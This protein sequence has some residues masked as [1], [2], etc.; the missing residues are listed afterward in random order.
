MPSPH[1]VSLTRVAL[2][3]CVIFA[4]AALRVW[5]SGRME[6]AFRIDEVHKISETY[7]LRLAE[8][9]DFANRDWFMDPVE[10]SNP[11][12]GK[13]LFGAAV[14]AAGLPLPEDLTVAALTAGGRRIPPPERVMM[15]RRWL[16]PARL[17]SLFATAAT[18][19]LVFMI[20]TRVA[21]VWAALLAVILQME[22]FLTQAFSATAVFDPLLTLAIVAAA[23]PAMVPI[24]GRPAW[25]WRLLLSGAMAGLA[26]EIRASGLVAALA[27]GVVIIGGMASRSRDLRSSIGGA[28]AAAAACVSIATSVNP[29]YWSLPTDPRVPGV[30]RSPQWLPGRIVSRYALQ[31]GDLQTILAGQPRFSGAVAKARFAFEYLF[32]DW[33]GIALLLGLVL[34]VLTLWRSDFRGWRLLF[35]WAAIVATVLVAWLP[36]AYPRYLLAAVPPLA[37]LSSLGWTAAISLAVRGVRR[38]NRSTIPVNGHES[39][40]ARTDESSEPRAHV[41][42]G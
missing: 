2:L 35:G 36:V 19:A 9:G 16:R 15:Y 28:L 18:A 4:A 24:A 31:M 23:A 21:G 20:V 17:V 26:F 25:M 30:F 27:A 8:R 32:G 3:A 1:S 12:V 11:P 34:A 41:G 5:I 38:G 37:V 22:S 7:F 10:R 13:Y 40:T 42:K 33:V 14:Q 39:R 29:F 6:G